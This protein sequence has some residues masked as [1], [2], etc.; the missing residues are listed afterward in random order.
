MTDLQKTEFELLKLL[1]QIC[2][3][4][5]LRYYLV[6]GSALGA[7]KFQGFIPW[8]DDIDVALPRKDYERFL[9]IAPE[10]LPEWVFLQNYRTDPA[11]PGLGSKLRDSRTTYIEKEA[12]KI[13][14]HHGVFIDVFPLDGQPADLRERKSFDRK[15]WNAYRRRYVRLIPFWHRDLGLTAASLLYRLFGC[16]SDT[17]AA[18]AQAEA[19][20]MTCPPD[21]SLYWCNYA[22]SMRAEEF[23][24]RDHYGQ[25]VMAHFE[26]LPVR[27]P[28][29]YHEYLV[30]KYGD[31]TQDVPDSEKHPPHAYLVDLNRPYTDYIVMD[32]KGNQTIVDR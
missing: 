12:L 10:E 30:Q 8:D 25:G 31:Y 22:N 4:Y 14:M 27:I 23:V 18:C 11:Y 29:K 9:E 3:K 19:V 20:A 32:K 21:E 17:A 26:G 1:V 15:R 28:E 24:P 7:V 6:C 16:F 2:D 5:Q 13:P